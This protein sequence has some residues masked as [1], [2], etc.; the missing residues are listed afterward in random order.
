MRARS[1]ESDTALPNLSP[2]W[3]PLAV[4]IASWVQDVPE[5]ANT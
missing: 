3:A 1:P 4:R 5:R 2:A